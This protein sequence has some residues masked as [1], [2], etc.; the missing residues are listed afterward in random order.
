MNC[1][2]LQFATIP[3][4]ILTTLCTMYTK[5]MSQKGNVD[6]CPVTMKT[7]KDREEAK[8]E[9]CGGQSVYHCLSDNEDRKW[10]RCV[11]KSLIKEGIQ[12]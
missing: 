3:D 4:E 12:L 8:R 11:E 1:K 6:V 7:W 2:T 5:Q 9:D 10:E